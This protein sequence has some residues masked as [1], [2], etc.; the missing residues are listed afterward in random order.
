MRAVP[1]PD[2]ALEALPDLVR[3]TPSGDTARVRAVSADL[4][5]LLDRLPRDGV[6]RLVAAV[7]AADAAWREH[8]GPA[9]ADRL[10]GLVEDLAVAV[11]AVAAVGTAPVAGEAVDAVGTA[12]VAVHTVDP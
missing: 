3:D 6:A 11:D 8:P 5:G 4:R 12:P 7:L 10:A 9:A 2:A 1:G